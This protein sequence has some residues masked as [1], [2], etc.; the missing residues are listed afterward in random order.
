M[1]APPPFDAGELSSARV[2][3][4]RLLDVVLAS[5]ARLGVTIAEGRH[6]F[7]LLV[8]LLLTSVLFS[9]P[10]GAVLG[11]PFSWRIG[12]LFL[13]STLICFPSLHVFC[14]Y[15]GARVSLAQ[16]LALAMTI[17]AVAAVFSLGFAPILGFLRWTVEPGE[18]RF[19]FGGLSAL[20]LAAA[21]L[22]GI[23]QL[24]RCLLAGRQLPLR[25]AYGVVLLGWHLVF[26]YVLV[27][28][29]DVLGLSS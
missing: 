4:D 24:W 22:A 9:I 17:P 27:R 23:G 25:F 11:L 20:L 15:L 3:P 26:L 1:S 7:G 28:M 5:P 12:A 29:G 18:G 21:T 16:N 2:R 8:L 10:Y 19:E 6:L 14:S 13:G